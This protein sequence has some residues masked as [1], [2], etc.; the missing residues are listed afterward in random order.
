M[1]QP[2]DPVS[3]LLDAY[4]D[5]LEGMGEEPSLDR[6]NDE[7]RAE[8]EQLIASLKA[9]Q[10]IDPDASRPSVAAL[11]AHAA[12][13]HVAATAAT[14]GAALQVTLQR[15]VDSRAQVLVDAAAQA[16]GLTSV[17]VTHVRGLRVRVLVEDKGTDVD[18]TYAA[19]LPA[20]AALFGAFR[21][22]N[23][24]LIATLGDTPAGA[25]VDR[26]D[27]VTAI[28]TPSGRPRPP[29]IS[30][31]VMDPA[32]A[33][34]RY[35]LDVMPA[36]EP[37]EYVASQHGAISLDGFDVDRVVTAAVEEIVASG[38]RARLT[39]KKLA[40]TGIEARETAAI[41]GALR[42]ALAGDFDESSFRQQV[43]ELVEVA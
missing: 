41:A 38:A 1:T 14:F 40:W 10:G 34:V 39:P 28:E 7:Q 18:A 42:G 6:L 11:V 12:A 22:T 20:L 16:A 35:V 32:E 26:D 24:V 17:L 5:Y 8:A 33:C 2:P 15:Q 23:A 30:R 4:F 3:E 43:E 13:R 19:R 29:R 25:V 36:F 9:A 21:D 27:I 37:F 31:P